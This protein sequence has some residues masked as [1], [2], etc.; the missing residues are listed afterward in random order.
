MII[1]KKGG[2]N[3][4]SRQGNRM[5]F[6]GLNVYY[7]FLC[8][9]AAKEIGTRW[10]WWWWKFDGV[11]KTFLFLSLNILHS[12]SQRKWKQWTLSKC[13]DC[14]EWAH[15]NFDAKWDRNR[16]KITKMKIIK[17][18]TK[19]KKNF[20]LSLYFT[21]KKVFCII[22]VFLIFAEFPQKNSVYN[23]ILGKHK[24]KRKIMLKKE[25][26]WLQKLFKTFAYLFLL[27][28]VAF[29]LWNIIF[30]LNLHFFVEFFIS[31]MKT[32]NFRLAKVPLWKKSKWFSFAYLVRR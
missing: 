32:S 2:V 4:F 28:F 11:N 5:I 6:C 31:S 17:T 1:I 13:V 21:F 16:R 24:Q 14:V 7:Y 10:W 3:C 23:F 27:S 20:S 22:F 8:K 26:K 12:A 29:D 9:E 18:K 15:D 25:R 30:S 19:S